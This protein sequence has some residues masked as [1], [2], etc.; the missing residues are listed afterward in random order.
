ML[1]VVGFG[2]YLYE[3]YSFFHRSP[4]FSISDGSIEIYYL[5]FLMLAVALPLLYIF[6]IAYFFDFGDALSF[7]LSTIFKFGN[8]NVYFQVKLFQYSIYI[9]LSALLFFRLAGGIYNFIFS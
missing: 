8:S 2:F 1:E 5:R 3:L 9:L 6:R 4:I 7:G